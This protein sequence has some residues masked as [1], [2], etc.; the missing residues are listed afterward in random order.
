MLT[1]TNK[2]DLSSYETHG[3]LDIPA[4]SILEHIKTE[5]SLMAYYELFTYVVHCNMIGEDNNKIPVSIRCSKYIGGK[6]PK[7]NCVKNKSRKSKDIYWPEVFDEDF[8][9]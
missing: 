3:S 4:G 8:P 6:I 5:T 2:I 7:V 1:L 9:E